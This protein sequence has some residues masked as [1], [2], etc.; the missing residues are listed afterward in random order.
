MKKKHAGLKYGDDTLL[1][2]LYALENGGDNANAS[3]LNEQLELITLTGKFSAMGMD[4]APDITGCVKSAQHDRG[5]DTAQ[6]PISPRVRR[7][8]RRPY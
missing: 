7:R 5:R 3:N 6:R 1:A 2:A 8:S 4:Y